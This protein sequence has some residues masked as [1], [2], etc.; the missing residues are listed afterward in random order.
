MKTRS[1]ISSEMQ[2]HNITDTPALES[3]TQ[4]ISTPSLNGTP[5]TSKQAKI[6]ANFSS[7]H[8][9]ILLRTALVNIEIRGDL[10]AVRALI[11]PGSQRTFI[12][13]KVRARLQIPY[14][15]SNFEIVGIGGQTQIANKE[16]KV[17]I[18]SPICNSR[19]HIDA[20]VL[21]KLTK[22]LPEVSFEISNGTEIQDLQLADPFFN[23]SAQI[24]LILGNDSE[25]FINIEGIRKNVCGE[26]SAYN[27]VFGW[28]LS[29]PNTNQVSCFHNIGY[30]V[31]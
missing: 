9:T 21:P 2:N 3:K 20:I 8:E 14:K 27:T 16:C 24:D 31:R 17:N 5:S 18:Y 29:G 28:V 30:T 12:S 22:Q 13:E 4:N 1:S 25:R 6:H 10:F 15:K 23:K 11:D 19:F 7:N 26:A